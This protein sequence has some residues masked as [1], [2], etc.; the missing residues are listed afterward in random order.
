MSNI[1]TST[2]NRFQTLAEARAA[3]QAFFDAEPAATHI[4]YNMDFSGGPLMVVW[5]DRD[6]VAWVDNPADRNG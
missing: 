5:I 1:Q 6:L 4:A 2:E 3:A